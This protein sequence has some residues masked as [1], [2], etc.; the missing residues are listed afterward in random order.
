MLSAETELGYFWSL[1]DQERA[2]FAKKR[3]VLSE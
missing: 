3:G 2:T 1:S